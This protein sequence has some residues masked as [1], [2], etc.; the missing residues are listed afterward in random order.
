[1]IA[2]NWIRLSFSCRNRIQQSPTSLEVEPRRHDSE[3]CV[4]LSYLV[5]RL[6]QSSTSFR[7]V[8]PAV[9]EKPDGLCM[10]LYLQLLL[11]SPSFR[12]SKPNIFVTREAPPKHPPSQPPPPPPFLWPSPCN[13][14]PC[15]MSLPSHF[16]FLV[17]GTKTLTRSIWNA[18]KRLA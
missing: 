5:V 7:N 4:T 9:V 15:W 18:G 8:L 16:Q 6:S 1:M 3:C 10:Q 13:R 2:A 12:Q 14:S 17:D 11:F